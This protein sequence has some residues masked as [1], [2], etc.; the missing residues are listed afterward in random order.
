MDLDRVIRR[1]RK[2]LRDGAV[3]L[4]DHVQLFHAAL[5]Q[6]RVAHDLRDDPVR[7]LDFF[8][9]DLDLLGASRALPSLSARWREKAAL[10]MMAERILDLVRDLGR[11]PA[12]RAQLPFAHR[13]LARF[14]LRPPLP[15]SSTCTP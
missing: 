4:L 3:Q 8:L 2:H 15:S 5:A 7:A 10:L 9:D 14:L 6:L 1:R 11:Q 13:E 12:R